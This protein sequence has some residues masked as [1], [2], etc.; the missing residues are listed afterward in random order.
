M[1]LEGDLFMSNISVQFKMDKISDILGRRGLETKGRVQQ[2]ID[3]EVLR[4]S[5]P[6]VPHLSGTLEESGPLSTDIGSGEVSWNTP[7]A[8][9][10]Y[11]NNGGRSGGLR[12]KLWFERMKVDHL[13][14]IV[15]GAAKIVGG[16]K[17]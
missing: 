7:Y 8:G 14:N 12:G 11:Y 3:S 17:V 2:F 9:K 5:S 10:Q 6:Y 4:R 15:D 1:A 16:K 13:D